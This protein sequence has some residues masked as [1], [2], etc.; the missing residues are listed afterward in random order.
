ML[1]WLSR[2]QKPE[3]TKLALTRQ[4][5]QR[6]FLQ[7]TGKIRTRSGF[8]WKTKSSCC[9]SYFNPQHFEEFFTE[10]RP[11]SE[12]CLDWAGKLFTLA[13]LSFTVCCFCFYWFETFASGSSK[14]VDCRSS[15]GRKLRDIVPDDENDVGLEPKT[16]SEQ[17]PAAEPNETEPAFAEPEV[18]MDS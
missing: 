13:A 6:G 8:N 9:P 14:P 16:T 11:L 12:S 2:R 10:S 1:N 18:A 4:N 7:R 5:P 3:K 15:F 17:P